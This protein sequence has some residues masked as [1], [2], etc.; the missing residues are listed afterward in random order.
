ML[1]CPPLPVCPT[2]KRPFLAAF[3]PVT[4]IAEVRFQG[5]ECLVAWP[6]PAW[7]SCSRLLDQARPARRR[8]AL[9]AA[10]I[11]DQPVIFLLPVL[12]SRSASATAC[13]SGKSGGVCRAANWEL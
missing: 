9:T 2:A 4:A 1:F 7:L 12:P 6:S 3:G 11:F 8:R 5:S 13:T 10:A